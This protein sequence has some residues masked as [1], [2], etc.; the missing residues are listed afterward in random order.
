MEILKNV[1]LALH[2]IGVVALLGGVLYQIGAMRAG[3]ARV[4]PAMMHGAWTMLVTGI[5]LVG[6]LYPLGHEVNNVKITVKLVV[7]IAIIVIALVNRKR[8]TVATWV[9]ASIGG[10]TV[11]NVLLATVWR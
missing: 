5:L 1:V 11:L 8:E 4:L 10:L 3:R 9:L 2:I 7:L 6:L